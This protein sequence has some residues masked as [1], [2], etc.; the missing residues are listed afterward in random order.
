MATV[1]A[2]ILTAAGLPSDAKVRCE[3]LSGTGVID[4]GDVLS[5]GVIEVE[6]ADFA[7]EGASLG[8]GNWR[9]TWWAGSRGAWLDITVPSGDGTYEIIQ[10]VDGVDATI[11]MQQWFDDP[12]AVAAVTVATN[13]SSLYLEEDGNT[14]PARG[15]HYRRQATDDEVD[16][17]RVVADGAGAT[18]VRVG[19]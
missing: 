19:N 5:Q 11:A 10:L 8:Q 12:D 17:V 2:T 4:T 18:F 13:V 15:V 6:A 7:D 3:R 16:G 9:L 14:P 1:I